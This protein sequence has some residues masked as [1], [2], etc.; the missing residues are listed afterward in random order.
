MNLTSSTGVLTRQISWS[1]LGIIIAITFSFWAEFDSYLNLWNCTP[2][3]FITSSLANKNQNHKKKTGCI[4]LLFFMKAK[5]CH[6]GIQGYPGVSRTPSCAKFT[7][8]PIS[9]S[10]T[11]LLGERKEGQ[12]VQSYESSD[13]ENMDRFHI[14]QFYCAL[15]VW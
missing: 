5:M 12:K 6:R 4:S 14:G 9:F 11:M 2:S 7:D 1:N 15:R 13:D 10:F 8:E 3:F